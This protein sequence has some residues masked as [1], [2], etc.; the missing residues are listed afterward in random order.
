MNDI[1][2]IEN[3]TNS[4]NRI[5]GSFPRQ[6]MVNNLAAS[7][8]IQAVLGAGD[9]ARNT[10]GDALNL[11]PGVNIPSVKSGNGIS[12]DVGNVAGNAAMFAAGG[13]GLEAARAASEALPLAG[14]AASYLGGSGLAA[15]LARRAAGSAVYGAV[16]NPQDRSSGAGEGAA[17]SAALDLL[18]A[19]ISG[20][21]K[22][23]KNFSP[24]AYAKIPQATSEAIVNNLSGGNSLEDSGKSLAKNIQNSYQ[25]NVNNVQQQYGNLFDQF[26]NNNIY[27]RMSPI[28]G[29]SQKGDYESLPKNVTNKYDSDIKNLH[30]SFIQTPTLNNAQKLQSQLGAS[31]GQ[32]QKARDQGTIDTAGNAQLSSYSKARNSLLGDITSYLGNQGVDAVS[33]YKSA[34]NN[35]K[36]NVVPYLSDPDLAKISQGNINNPTVSQITGIFKNPESQINKVVSDIGEPLNNS[37]LYAHIGNNKITPQKLTNSMGLLDKNGL[38]SY[39]T[40]GV[41]DQMDTLGQQLSKLDTVK[42]NSAAAKKFLGAASLGSVGLHFGLPGGEV[43]GGIGG[44]LGAGL[45]ASV[46]PN[47]TRNIPNLNTGVSN[48]ISR[49]YPYIA[50]TVRANATRGNQQ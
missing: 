7:P 35:W 29:T 15:S 13:E 11:I 16:T 4:Q 32:L 17:T 31:I 39:I 37:I 10:M 5:S 33:A 22:S 46:M 40:P 23:L 47:L 8:G 34:T 43:L 3:N 19:G 9:A 21:G 12:Y 44:L 27:N 20:I 38:G 18:P 48:A 42:S 2:N 6:S 28:F 45:G 41:S 49:A 24:T 1:A 25:A 36:Q 50:N 30:Y 26:G 14:S